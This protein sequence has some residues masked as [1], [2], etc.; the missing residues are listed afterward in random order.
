MRVWPKS[1]IVVKT[2]TTTKRYGKRN[3]LNENENLILST[4]TNKIKSSSSNKTV[5]FR[6]W[7]GL[8]SETG[9]GK[10]TFVTF[11]N[12]EFS[13]IQRKIDRFSQTEND[14]LK[15]NE[16]TDK[17][18]SEIKTWTL[19]R[20]TGNRFPKRQ[21]MNQLFVTFSLLPMI[22]WP[23]T[24]EPRFSLFVLEMHRKFDTTEEWDKSKR[25]V[26]KE[27]NEKAKATEKR[28]RN[29]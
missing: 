20:F 22:S 13:M 14:E 21:Q 12:I 19:T 4:S 9:K 10:E 15:S 23:A 3:V 18:T 17:N 8:S 2:T 11:E 27:K 5:Y 26:G 1:S 29:C 7:S 6:L 28:M 24:N 25:T 16:T